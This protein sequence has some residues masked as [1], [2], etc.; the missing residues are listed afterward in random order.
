M[1]SHWKDLGVITLMG[2]VVVS[3]SRPTR[4]GYSWKAGWGWKRDLDC[5]RRRPRQFFLWSR[6]ASWLRDCAYKGGRPIPT[7]S[8]S[9]VPGASP[10]MQHTTWIVSKVSQQAAGYQRRAGQLTH[11]KPAKSES[12]TTGGPTSVVTR[13]APAS[14]RLG[15]VTGPVVSQQ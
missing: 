12:C 9:L 11:Q 10:K 4:T 6:P 2:L 5:E 8:P 13:S 15:E 7:T 14:F 1:V 3:R